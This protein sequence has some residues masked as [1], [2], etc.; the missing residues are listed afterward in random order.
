MMLVFIF[1]FLLLEDKDTI[2]GSE[3]LIIIK[4]NVFC[5]IIIILD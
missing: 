5:V 1:G 4:I 3:N 2:N